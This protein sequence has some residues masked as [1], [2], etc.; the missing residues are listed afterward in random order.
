MAVSTDADFENHLDE[1]LA[2]RRIEL[3][4]YATQLQSASRQN[5]SSPLSR[6]L[7]RGLATLLYAHW[8]GYGKIAFESYLKVVLK[9]KPVAREANDGLLTSHALQILRRMDAG[10]GQA[11]AE[12]IELARGNSSTRLRL[13]QEKMVNTKS[14]LRHEVLEGIME[15]L[16]VPCDEF[17]TKKNLIDK[18]L[19]DRRNDIAHGRAYF[20][21]PSEV[22]ELHAEVLSMMEA[23]RDITIGQLRTQGYRV[24]KIPA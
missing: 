9:R 15:A 19:C 2:W 8:E 7:S 21:P 18:L 3:S 24:P 10:D 16:G 5:P 12:L 4:A 6:A 1:E 13:P 11:A 20:P 17:S 23:I 14:N 22:L